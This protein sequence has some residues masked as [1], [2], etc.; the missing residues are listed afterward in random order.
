MSR[1][2]PAVEFSALRQLCE[3]RID[4]AITKLE[5]L[6]TD[7]LLLRADLV[8]ERLRFFRRIIADLALL[9]TTA[10]TTLTRPHQDD[11]ALSRLVFRIHQEID[12]PLPPP[13]VTCLSREYFSINTSL[14]LLEVPLAESDFL[15]HLPDLYHEIAH[16]LI[17]TRN[18]PRIASYQSEYNAFLKTVS[19]HF[20]SERKANMKSTG[21]KEYFDR[22]FHILEYY[23]IRGWANEIFCDLFAVYTL[24]PAYAWA[25][26][27]LTVSQEAD[28]YDVQIPGFMS[29]PPDQ[30]RMESML[31]GLELM[32]FVTPVSEIRQH[33]D[34]FVKATGARPT[35]IY[36]R[37]CPS[38]LLAAA[39]VRAH[40]GTKSIGCRIVSQET[41]SPVH[42]LLNK[43]W[44][45]FWSSPNTYHDWERRTIAS[46]KTTDAREKLLP[47]GSELQDAR[48]MPA[49]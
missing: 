19:Q 49:G 28:P 9:E 40:E 6:L 18:N 42:D 15:L 31:M 21:P 30:A 36:R 39:A 41:S 32:G 10:I 47:E 24:G 23:W 25:H 16:P 8:Q 27:H 48:E 22:V 12:Y 17:A 29:H 37:A 33:W 13:V 34:A 38:E 46:L 43:A 11:I 44:E 26:F 20:D 1:A 45:R 35:P 3:D 5:E 7:P 14:R 4:D 2:L